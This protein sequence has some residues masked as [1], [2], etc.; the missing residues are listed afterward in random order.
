MAIRGQ[1]VYAARQPL[2]PISYEPK[3]LGPLSQVN[4]A[5]EKVRANKAR[6]RMVLKL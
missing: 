3:G 6:Y 1:A 2:Q 5:I 4:A